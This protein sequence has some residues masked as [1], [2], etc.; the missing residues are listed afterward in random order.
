MI[1]ICLALAA[2]TPT[3]PA[4][5]ASTSAAV[6]T[7]APTPQ[8]PA[9]RAA[10]RSGKGAEALAA[11]A[12]E[13]VPA[14]MVPG[15]HAEAL[16][17]AGKADEACRVVGASSSSG[18]AVVVA[19]ARCALDAGK[20]DAALALLANVPAEAIVLVI[21]D[22]ALLAALSTPT[23]ARLLAPALELPIAAFDP[24]ARA[25]SARVLAAL[26]F[27]DDVSVSTRA[28]ERLI[29]ELT[30]QPQAQAAL[31]A[32]GAAGQTPAAR[33][34]RAA[35]LE[36]IQKNAEAVA[37]VKDLV[38]VDCEAA[39]I[40]GRAE[41]KL[42]HYAPARAALK[43][44]MAERCGD[45]V[46]KARYLDVKLAT[47]QK[48][49]NAEGVA[50]GFAKDY[51]SDVLVDDVL[52]WLAEIQAARGDLVAE[53]ATLERLIAEHPDGDMV[54]EARLRLAMRLAAADDVVGARA[55][56]AAAIASLTTANKKPVELDRAR[57]WHARL[58][59]APSLTSW[60][61]AD[62][63]TEGTRLLTRF[64]NERPAGYYGRLA[65]LVLGV[66]PSTRSRTSLP[67]GSVVGVPLELRNQRSWSEARLA[68]DAGFDDAAA[69]LLAS[70]DG[71][72]DVDSAMA[73]AA[74]FVAV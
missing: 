33:V 44:A 31:S 18:A 71:V 70:I 10:I 63:V 72:R 59:L 13:Q 27:V 36:R 25:R 37:L 68:A 50:R 55:V 17:L 35:T 54:D 57:Y 23:S 52:L 48:G 61:R 7:V 43:K 5:S 69:L 45:V 3:A 66:A 2:V 26:A 40:T 46:K 67:S 22:D 8:W 42:R 14:T 47:I 53:R 9:S 29:D 32:L 64:A 74:L 20:P 51:G 62:D 30:E 58:A 34:K 56:L 38:D 60:E 4:S 21:N 6:T 15:L 24:V 49:A 73:I 16:L 19:R 28:R 1:W 11:L 39:L 65:A 41:R 12:T